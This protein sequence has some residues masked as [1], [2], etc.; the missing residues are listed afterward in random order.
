MPLLSP[1]HPVDHKAAQTPHFISHEDGGYVLKPGALPEV[2]GYLNRRRAL[3]GWGDAVV[4]G[5]LMFAIL[6]VLLPMLMALITS[7]ENHEKFF[8]FWDFTLMA[9]ALLAVVAFVVNMALLRWDYQ[10]L[11][12]G[13]PAAK[14]QDAYLDPFFQKSKNPD[15]LELQAHEAA[16][17]Y[18]Y[19]LTAVEQ[20]T[21]FLAYQQLAAAYALLTLGEQD[22]AVRDS[23]ED[24]C[25]LFDPLQQKS[26]STEEEVAQ[27]LAQ[28]RARYDDLMGQK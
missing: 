20:E 12:K 14:L 28:A 8:S 21:H 15:A 2:E 11:P 22:S 18:H 17:A 24:R 23:F 3:Q 26:E 27:Q 5:C 4:V 13:I 1:K 9:S 25:R 16:L 6:G 19:N 10:K 7:V